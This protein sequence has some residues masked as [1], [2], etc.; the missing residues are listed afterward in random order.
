MT[1]ITVKKKLKQFTLDVSLKFGREMAVLGG[2]NGSGKTTLLRIIAGL[3]A[4][5]EGCISVAGKVFFDNSENLMPEE[6]ITGYVSQDPSLF[7]WLTVED[8]IRF[9]SKGSVDTDWFA[10]LLKNLD[11]AHLASRYPAT[12]SGGE[13]QRVSLARTLFP[14]P[15]ILLMDEPF[16]AI[17]KDMR[18]RLRQ[19]LKDLQEKWQIPAIIVS[20]DHA[21]TH[22]LGDKVFE[23]TDGKIT[24]RGERGKIAASTL[25]SY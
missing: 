8:N 10:S 13:A 1:I 5:D 15:R 22:V 14:R 7:P 16:S 6:R 17:D 9:G 20:H 21:E 19:Y 24:A 12:L 25:I 4:P 2:A 18:P 23:L 11:L 3:E